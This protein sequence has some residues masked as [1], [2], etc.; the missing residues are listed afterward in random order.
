MIRRKRNLVRRSAGRKWRE[1]SPAHSRTDRTGHDDQRARR[2]VG[3]GPLA[4]GTRSRKHA[5]QQH[6]ILVLAVPVDLEL[7]QGHP[8]PHHSPSDPHVRPLDRKQ[9]LV[10]LAGLSQLGETG[11]STKLAK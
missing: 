11:I 9:A 10:L 6:P 2:S 3:A 5:R 7:V 8:L 1:N 4:T